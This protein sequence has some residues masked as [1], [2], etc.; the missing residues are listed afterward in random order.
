MPGSAAA[1]GSARPWRRKFVTGRA[2]AFILLQ[3]AV[4]LAAW[5]FIAGWSFLWERM[6][7][8][9]PLSD[10]RFPIIGSTAAMIARFPVWGCGLGAWPAVYPEFALF[11]IGLQVNQAHCDWLQWAAEGGVPLLLAFVILAALLGRPLVRSVWG[12][13]FLAVLMHASMDYPFHQL[14]AFTALLFCTAIVAAETARS[15]PEPNRNSSERPAK[16]H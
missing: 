7:G 1:S 10:L 3:A 15:D 16:R 11:D 6:T 12:V 8:L 9:D 13:G 4:L 2:A 5:G 14:P